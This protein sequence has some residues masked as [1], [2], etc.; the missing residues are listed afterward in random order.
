[1]T[2]VSSG[3]FRAFHVV[4]VPLEY[5][6]S[7]PPYSTYVIVNCLCFV[8]NKECLQGIN[9]SFATA[10]CR[11]NGFQIAETSLVALLHCT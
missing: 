8:Q 11:L 5:I 1:M 3:P 4:F 2:E 10:Q 9:S 6:W 7:V